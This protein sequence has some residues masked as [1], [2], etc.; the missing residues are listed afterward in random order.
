MSKYLYIIIPIVFM[1][2]FAGYYVVETKKMEVIRL[3]REAKAK[4]DAEEAA[5]KQDELRKRSAEEARIAAEKRAA[6]QKAKDDAKEATYQEGLQKIRNERDKYIADQ[7]KYKEEI[8]VLEKELA[9]ILADIEK[10]S[11][12]S[13]TMNQSIVAALIERQNAEM[14]VQRL[15]NVVARHAT[16]SPM[17]RLPES[18][19]T[20]T[21]GGAGVAGPAGR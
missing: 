12:E 17:T 20:S 5:R 4:A 9:D 15:A 13:V 10:L 14:E 16:D 18:M 21:S 11:R 6:D 7:N 2:L 1:G 8:A 19:T 3:E